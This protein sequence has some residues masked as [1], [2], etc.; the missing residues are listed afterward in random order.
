MGGS[1]FLGGAKPNLADL[2]AFGV[3]RAVE[4]GGRALALP[5]AASVCRRWRLPCVACH[6]V[7]ALVPPLRTS[8]GLLRVSLRMAATAHCAMDAG[9]RWMQQACYVLPRYACAGLGT[10]SPTASHAYHT[11]RTQYTP[12]FKDAMA[13]SRIAPWF[14]RMSATVGPSSRVEQ[15]PS[16]QQ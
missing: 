14:L 12:T 7:H 15:R 3:L 6:R 11:H 2:A 16:A 13:H 5:M 10:A 1:P 9:G 8:F 4:V